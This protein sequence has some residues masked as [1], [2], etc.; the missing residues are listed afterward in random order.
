MPTRAQREVVR[1]ELLQLMRRFGDPISNGD[2]LRL[3]TG[4]GWPDGFGLESRDRETPCVCPAG[5]EAL[6]IDRHN[7][8]P[9][10]RYARF[11][12]ET[13]RDC[14]LLSGC[15]VDRIGFHLRLPLASVEGASQL[16][17]DLEDPDCGLG[18]LSRLVDHMPC[19]V[20]WD[21]AR[22]DL[23]GDLYLCPESG[24]EPLGNVLEADLVDLWYG[25]EAN[26]FRYL[27]QIGA[28]VRP[29]V[30]RMVCR[31]R[32]RLLPTFGRLL[33]RIHRLT[34]EQREAL[35]QAGEPERL[36]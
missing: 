13:C 27:G 5:V 23:R 9:S 2:T 18:R 20:G 16:V 1:E 22:I 33:R 31:Q 32:C 14:H 10:A 12:P 26:E 30:D 21:T 25:P 17:S 35:E 6:R 4:S 3:S 28:R 34:R 29:T 7:S 24:V 19:L 8:D 15:P 36:R 11:D